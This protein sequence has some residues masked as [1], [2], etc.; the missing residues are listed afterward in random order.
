[1]NYQKNF[2][3]IHPHYSTELIKCSICEKEIK[4]INMKHHKQTFNCKLIAEA[5]SIQL[6]KD[7]EYLK[8]QKTY[9]DLSKSI[10][11]TIKNAYPNE[12]TYKT[13]ISCL[14][15][16][17]NDY[18]DSELSSFDVND[19]YDHKE[20]IGYINKNIKA[21]NTKQVY[22][23]MIKNILKLFDGFPESII[24]IYDMEYRNL[25]KYN[26]HEA[27]E[28]KE[29]P[30]TDKDKYITFEQLVKLRDKIKSKISNIY[31][32]NYL[33]YIILC[34]YSYLPPM[35]GQDLYNCYLINEKEIEIEYNNDNYISLESG[36]M[37]INQYKTS[38]TYGQNKII[39]DEELL[40]ILRKFKE[41]TNSVYLLP[42]LTNINEN[43]TQSYFTHILNDIFKRKISVQQ[44]RQ[45]YT[46]EQ[47]DKFNNAKT[48]EEKEKIAEQ[49]GKDSKAMKHSLS[50]HIHK[51]TKYSKTK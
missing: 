51:Y 20:L 30:E 24:T 9:N 6:K 38:K 35:R 2:K 40:D 13:Y 33:H 36:E 22:F 21:N 1:M 23:N 28:K 5:K 49:I 3:K 34:L 10:Q 7:E 47:M 41:I 8:K 15:K 25:R 17:Y 11:N 27:E 26:E 42:K 46:S 16:L 37:V 19:F 43:L 12:N 50:C 39:L 44:L 32:K 14:R 48:N 31:D 29:T 4:R 18:F 45:I